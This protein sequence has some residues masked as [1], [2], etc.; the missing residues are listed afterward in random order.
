M[1][2]F[3]L[4]TA[5]YPFDRAINWLQELLRREIIVEPVILQHGVTSVASLSHPLVKSVVGLSRDEMHLAVKDASIVISH[6]GQGSTR[7]LADMGVPFVLLPR[8]KR[9]REH[10]DDHQLLFARAVEKLGV[11]HCTELNQ[12]MASI[13]EPPPPFQGKLFQASLLVDHLIAKYSRSQELSFHE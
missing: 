5:V 12:L 10:V 2:L 4:G 8:L 1:I 13:I 9:Y 11:R 6:A 3:T 7:T